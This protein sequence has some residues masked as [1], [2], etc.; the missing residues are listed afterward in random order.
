M[1]FPSAKAVAH[2]PPTLLSLPEGETGLLVIKITK[3]TPFHGYAGDSQ[4]TERKILRDVLVKGDTFF[5]S[6]DLLMIDHER[7]VYFQD[8]VGDTFR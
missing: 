1:T 8:R 7:F 5:N 4:K 3:N 2:Q 6:G